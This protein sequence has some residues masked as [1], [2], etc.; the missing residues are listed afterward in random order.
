M[1]VAVTNAAFLGVEFTVIFP[2]YFSPA[3]VERSGTPVGCKKWLATAYFV[4][5]TINIGSSFSILR[6]PKV[7][8]GILLSL[9]FHL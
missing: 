6:D 5:S 2:T 7:A 8:N 4:I 1:Q 3:G 9:N